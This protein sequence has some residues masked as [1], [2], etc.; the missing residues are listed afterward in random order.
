MNKEIQQKI[1]AVC[2]EKIAKKGTNVGL[3]FYAFFKNKNDNPKLLMEVAKWWIETHELDHF[4][5][6]VKVKAMI[7]ENK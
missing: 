4:E 5:K 3:S 7:L 1:I 2:E 6:A